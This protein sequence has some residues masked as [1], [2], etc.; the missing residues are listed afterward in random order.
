M[1]DSLRQQQFALSRHLRDPAANPPPPG[2]EDRRLAIYRDLFFNNIAG[3]LAGNF[4]VIQTTLGESS[5][6]RLVR[7]FYAQHRSRTPLFPEVPREFIRFLET[8]A[9]HDG[10]DPPWLVELAHYEWVELAL[11][12]ADDETPAHDAQGD[13]LSGVP[14][15]SPTAWALAYRWPVPHIGPDHQPTTAPEAPTLLLVRRDARQQVRFAELSPLVYRLLVL[16]GE[17]TPCSGLQILRRL[18]EEAGVSADEDF[19]AQGAAMLERMREEGTL[20]GTRSS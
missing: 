12:L 18:G 6:R 14:V 17:D 15:V 3:L 5:W 4:P 11:Q 19:I 1:V 10:D 16:L 7:A 20:L 9:E 2:V 8:R 13:L